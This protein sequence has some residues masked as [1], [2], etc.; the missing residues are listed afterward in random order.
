MA[1]LRSA[2]S[3]LVD[4]AERYQRIGSHERLQGIIFPSLRSRELVDNDDKKERQ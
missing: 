2:E 4:I 3:R 1:E